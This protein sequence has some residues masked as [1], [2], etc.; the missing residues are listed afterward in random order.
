MKVRFLYCWEP[1]DV[2]G[3]KPTMKWR[4][5]KGMRL[6]EEVVS[7]VPVAEKELPPVPEPVAEETQKKAAAVVEEGVEAP[8]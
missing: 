8:Q 6:T 5:G 2:R 7:A 1:R 4:R 3:A